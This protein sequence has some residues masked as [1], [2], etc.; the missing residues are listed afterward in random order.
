MTD[1]PLRRLAALG[2]SVWLDDLQRGMLKTGG[3]LERLIEEDG[4]SGVTSNPAIFERA[5]DGSTDYDLALQTLAQALPR[6]EDLYENLTLQ[7]V[8]RAADLLRPRFEDS[9]G[10]DGFVSIEV[11]PRLARDPIGSIAEARRLWEKLDRPNILIKL[12]GTLDGLPAIGQLLRDGININV[13]LLFSL[14]RYQQVHEAYL[15]ALEDRVRRQQPVDRLRSVASF[16]LSR[17]DVLL[18]PRLEELVRTNSPQAPLAGDLLGQLAI[19]H[20]KLAFQKWREVL[21][22]SRW[23]ALSVR[24]AQPQRLLWASTSPKN[25]GLDPLHYVEPLI[26][27]DTVTTLPMETLIEYRKHGRPQL[28]IAEHLNDAIRRMR[29][30]EELGLSLRDAYRTL[31]D[32]GI[33]RFVESYDKVLLSLRQKASHPCLD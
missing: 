16:F 9:A 27:R 5:I 13:T 28:R 26:A 11:S 4:L 8:G 15:S 17:I 10:K 24:G 6:P 20:A 2:Q 23:R 18:W 25:A 19:A 21:K 31:E 29:T 12:P 14:E 30:A 33:R 22:G 1:Q 32:D 7:D 3:L